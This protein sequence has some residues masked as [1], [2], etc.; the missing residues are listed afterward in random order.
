MLLRRRPRR[1]AAVVGLI[2]GLALL[3][4]AVVDGG[5]ASPTRAEP[6]AGEAAVPHA[7]IVAGP[8]QAR[9]DQPSWG[10]TDLPTPLS[11]TVL[12]AAAVAVV[13]VLVA[14]D[15]PHHRTPTLRVARHRGPPVIG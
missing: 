2:A 10:V 12:V 1:A 15:G 9:E 4:G 8:T 11:G 6:A 7:D 5:M 3:L 14:R 13:V